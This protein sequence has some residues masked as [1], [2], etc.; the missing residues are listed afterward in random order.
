MFSD[1]VSVLH[2]PDLLLACATIQITPFMLASTPDRS[3]SI[4]L[5]EYRS[6]GRP[7]PIIYDDRVENRLVKITSD[8]L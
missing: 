1:P 8:K 5:C 2:L 4:R 7:A 3:L 6:V